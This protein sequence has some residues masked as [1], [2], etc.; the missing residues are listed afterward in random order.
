MG[1]QPVCLLPSPPHHL[2][3]PASQTLE[4]PSNLW[5]V[6][7]LPNGDLVTACSDHVARIWTQVRVAARRAWCCACWPCRVPA[8][9]MVVV[10]TG[11]PGSDASKPMLAVHA[12]CRLLSV[13]RRL[14]L[15]RQGW[16]CCLNAGP[17]QYWVVARGLLSDASIAWCLLS[18]AWP[19]L[20]HQPADC[21]RAPPVHRP[22]MRRWL[23]RRKLQPLP[24]RRVAAVAAAACLRA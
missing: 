1:P 17:A 21:S 3:V 19:A 12:P 20:V 13:L 8:C 23:Q 14:K 4:H 9:S 15:H 7:F 10:P 16:V 6:A 2:P 18:L 24:S 5:G 11:V 22:T